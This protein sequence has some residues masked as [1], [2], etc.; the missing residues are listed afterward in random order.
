MRK[1]MM[2]LLGVLLLALVTGCAGMRCPMRNCCPMKAKKEAKVQR[3][4]W[5]IGLKPEKIAY[6][7]ELHANA[8]PAVQKKIT[9][10]NL[11]NYSIYMTQLEDGRYYLFSYVE[12]VGD[13][14]AA[15]MAKMGEDP[16]TQRWWKETD[17]CQ[18]PLS[19]R[20]KSDRWWMTME[21]VFHQD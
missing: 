18:I 3:F 21:E 7:K 8:W 16:E 5:V 13:D 9:E 1:W 15:D 4:G 11:R 14:F 2:P 19:N 17:P 20:P 10:C 6:Y 12:Y